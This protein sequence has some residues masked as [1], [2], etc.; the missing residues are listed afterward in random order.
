MITF[1]LWFKIY[2]GWSF[3]SLIC[4]SYLLVTK[5]KRIAK[6]YQLPDA[7]KKESRGKFKDH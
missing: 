5:D 1:P 7:K 4:Q 3:I 6:I 2:L